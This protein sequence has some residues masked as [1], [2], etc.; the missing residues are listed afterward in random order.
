MDGK[1][2]SKHVEVRRPLMRELDADG[3]GK[4]S[5]AEARLSPL[6]AS[7]RQR[8]NP[9]LEQLDQNK[10]VSRG[11]IEQDVMK[12]FSDYVTYRQDDSAATNDGELF[13]IL[14]QDGSGFIELAEMR[15]AALRILERDSDRDQCITLDELA[16]IVANPTP[17]VAVEMPLAASEQPP[18]RISET[19]RDGGD[20]GL[21][22]L[23]GDVFR[24]YYRNRDRQLS[25]DELGWDAEFD[26]WTATGAAG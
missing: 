9:F 2:L 10:V 21:V 5:K 11:E 26:G 17:F 19:L 15:T 18:P 4:L 1:A 14:D 16:P 7:S 6:R 3:D 23:I 24:K 8:G 13:A 20:N 25:I 22:R 12:V